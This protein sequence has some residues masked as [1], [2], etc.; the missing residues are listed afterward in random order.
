MFTSPT[1]SST[2]SPI[3]T[4]SSTAS[5]TATSTASL[6]ASTTRTASATLSTVPRRL[7][8]GDVIVL[9]LGDSVLGFN[10]TTAKPLYLD[11]IASNGTVNDVRTNLLRTIT[12]P[13]QPNRELN[14]PAC[15]LGFGISP[16]WITDADGLPSISPD[17]ALVSFPCF[18]VSSGN[19]ILMSAG[20]VI[21]SLNWTGA[22]Q[23]GAE[24]PDTF[25]GQAFGPGTGVHNAVARDVS[26][27][28]GFYLAGMSDGNWG[29]RWTPSQFSNASSYIIGQ[30]EFQPGFTDAR[31]IGI[32]PDGQLYGVSSYFDYFNGL[33]FLG[34]GTPTTELTDKNTQVVRMTPEL[35]TST[36]LTMWSVAWENCTSFWAAMDG[37][38]TSVGIVY[39]YRRDA[40]GKFR[41]KRTLPLTPRL[42]PGQLQM[43][44]QG[45]PVYSI[46]GRMENRSNTSSE[47]V[48]YAA[49]AD[50]VWQFWTRSG[51]L[52]IIYA[53]GPSEVFRGVV[54]APVPVVL[55]LTA[56]PSRSPT[57]SAT[58]SQTSSGTATPPVSSVSAIPTLTRSGTSP[59]SAT[60][61][62]SGTLS[63]TGSNSRSGAA[64]PSRSSSG[65]AAPTA[66]SSSSPSISLSSSPSGTPSSSQTA[67]TSV[68]PSGSPTAGS[69]FSSTGSSTGTSSRSRT[70]TA[71][72]TATPSP[73]SPVCR[74][75]VNKV[76]SLEGLS[77]TSP[78]VSS[79]VA[80]NLGLYTSGTCTYGFKSFANGPR[81]VYRLFLGE[82]V[83]LG[84]TLNITTC[85]LTKNNTVA[86]IGT[87][88][89]TWQ[90]PFACI[91]GNDD[92]GDA[93]NGSIPRCSSNPGAAA[94]SI[95]GASSRVYFIQVGSATG[96]DFVSGISWSYK[97]PASPT[98]S[99]S[100]SRSR[101]VSPS[102][103]GSRTKTRSR[104]G[105]RK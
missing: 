70:G 18:N 73:T 87:G 92:A 23:I 4:A 81:L 26:A 68:S 67:S 94:L 83:A 10:D 91:R 37:D 29:F 58:G 16:G 46:S 69:T 42:P 12:V 36:T 8:A 40:D 53:A 63:A 9:K 11:V 22:L 56:T 86:Y 59:P 104:S 28:G 64:T 30:Y 39:N 82:S 105:K 99:G 33:I 95:T 5:S 14:R 93:G 3:A 103:S 25:F 74:S 41:K 98:K 65:T 32:N 45:L 97:P 79:K 77:G 80:G 31:W 19:S 7:G 49:S 35:T 102:S 27:Y 60:G 44:N 66:T 61:T 24:V 100:S 62:S 88:C 1:A 48:L 34:S 43:G 90:L 52:Y 101:T 85:G 13:S 75:P 76:T 72:A 71:A 54:V 78:P 6:S 89:P 51:E 47:F 20:K 55:L 84:G 50:T 57:P 38:P 15:T 17:G 2:T 96:A 21:A